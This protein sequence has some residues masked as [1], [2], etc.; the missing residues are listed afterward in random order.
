MHG[1]SS[2]ESTAV[3]GKAWVQL[4][5]VWGSGGAEVRLER[6]GSTSCRVG[7]SGGWL[8]NVLLDRREVPHHLWF[9]HGEL[10][11]VGS[12]FG[13]CSSQGLPVHSRNASQWCRVRMRRGEAQKC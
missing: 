7:E 11:G 8:G 6:P 10:S 13:S 3:V 2:K 4:C 9:G 1:S 12:A 5:V